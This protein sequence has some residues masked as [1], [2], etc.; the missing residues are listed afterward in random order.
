MWSPQGEGS[1]KNLCA[2]ADL[3]QEELLLGDG[4]EA[5]DGK[6]CVCVCACTC[7]HV[8]TGKITEQVL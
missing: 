7:V 3:S 1:A 4:D 2:S 5:I 6:V 8:Y